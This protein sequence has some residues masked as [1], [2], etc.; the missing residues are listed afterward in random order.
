MRKIAS[1]E[2]RMT[3][4]RLPGKVLMP[5][6]GK[7]M[8]RLLI[9]RLQQVPELDGIVLATT[10]NATDDPVVALGR[11]LGI[12]VFRGSENDVLGRVCGALAS[13]D[14]DVAIEITGDCPLVDPNIVSACIT[15]FLRT[16][17][18]H[19][20]LANTT[21]PSL[22]SPHGLDVQVFN[23]ADLYQIEKETSAPDD[24]EHVS[25]P[26]YRPENQARWN[27]RF[28][29]FYPD[30][31]SHSVWLSLDYMEDYVLLRKA[32]E[33]LGQGDPFFGAENLIKFALSEPEL[34]KACLAL[35]GWA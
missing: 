7:P 2:A 1:I 24:R 22:G 33:T 28:I 13:V 5:A 30:D 12:H 4:S 21:G 31:L 3:S 29:D 16:R 19:H 15:E 32:Q 8:L 20:Y 23:A 27:P 35:R 34:T 10:I 26:F 14:A 6:G 18:T 11:Q 17:V 25:L 9:E